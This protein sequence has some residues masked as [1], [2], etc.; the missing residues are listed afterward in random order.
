MDSALERLQRYSWH[1]VRLFPL[2][3]LCGL[4]IIYSVSRPGMRDHWLLIGLVLMLHTVHVGYST[5]LGAV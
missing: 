5:A 3:C 1:Q 4:L 2:F